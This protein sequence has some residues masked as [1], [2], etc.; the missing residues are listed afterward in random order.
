[1]MK[2]NWNVISDKES[3]PPEGIEVLISDGINN[4]VAY[5]VRSYPPK[6]VK[7]NIKEDNISDF[8]QFVPI[9]WGFIPILEEPKTIVPIDE[10]DSNVP[11]IT[12]GLLIH[13]ESYLSKIKSFFESIKI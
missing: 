1:M 9:M 7:V 3:F 13:I 5:Y 4:D 11:S 2:F 6:W 12:K 8:I 10:F